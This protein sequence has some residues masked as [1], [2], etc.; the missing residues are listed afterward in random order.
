M[1]DKIWRTVQ[2]VFVVLGF[3][4]L[5]VAGGWILC[6]RASESPDPLPKYLIWYDEL[7][8]ACSDQPIQCTCGMLSET[9]AVRDAL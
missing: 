9:A 6:E 8:Y 5:G 2:Q 7:V 1:G 3:T 4:L